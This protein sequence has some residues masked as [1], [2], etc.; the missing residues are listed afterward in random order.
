MLAG[1]RIFHLTTSVQTVGYAATENWIVHYRADVL[2]LR[3][4]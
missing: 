2:R 1:E 4:R 3:R